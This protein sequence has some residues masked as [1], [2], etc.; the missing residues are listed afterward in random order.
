MIGKGTTNGKKFY[1]CSGEMII[2][3]KVTHLNEGE[4]TMKMKPKMHNQEDYELDNIYNDEDVHY[5]TSSNSVIWY[6]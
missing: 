6:S 3:S 1:I 5:E 4:L 2:L